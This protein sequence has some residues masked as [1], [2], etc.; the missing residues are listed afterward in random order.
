[1]SYVDSCSSDTTVDLAISARIDHEVWHPSL[2]KGSSIKILLR[3]ERWHDPWQHVDVDH[4]KGSA[5]LR[6]RIL[7]IQGFQLLLA[8]VFDV[9]L[10]VFMQFQTE[11]HVIINSHV[12]VKSVVWNTMAMSRSFGATSLTTTPSI[13]A[14]PSVMSSRP[15]IIRRVVDLPHPEG[16]TKTINSLSLMS[17]LKSSTE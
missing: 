11:S 7:S 8:H 6:S 3:H 4:L 9:F 17:K 2:T 15:A 13:D 5:G 1:M 12:W 16:P 10:A 14:V